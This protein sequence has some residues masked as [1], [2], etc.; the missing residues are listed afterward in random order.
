[1]VKC[2]LP[3]LDLRVRFPL[4]AFSVLHS[5]AVDWFMDMHSSQI[6]IE[7]IAINEVSE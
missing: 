4:P 3:K 7:G 6:E 5:Y 1:M 2:H